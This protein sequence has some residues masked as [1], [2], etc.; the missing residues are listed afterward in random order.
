MSN[1]KL[2][3]HRLTFSKEVTLDGVRVCTDPKLVPKAVRRSI[4]KGS[5]EQYERQLVTRYLSPS[6]RVLEIGAASGLVTLVCARQ[7]GAANVVA[8]EANPVME[9]LIRKNFELNGWQPNLV[10][11]AV[12]VDGGDVQF[13]ASDNVY[14][15]S[16]IDRSETVAGRKITVPSDPFQHVLD[17]VRPTT[18]VMDVEGAEIALLANVQLEGVC[19]IIVE[20]HPHITGADAVQAMT[21]SLS[22]QGFTVRETAHKTL[23]LT[24]D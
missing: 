3:L 19:R 10:M 21:D 6:D 4:I 12:T 15:S 22:R 18:V 20:V 5:H 14:S 9:P 24:R 17:K 1:L 7:C 11:R 16:V 2:L 13:F 8:Y 23:L